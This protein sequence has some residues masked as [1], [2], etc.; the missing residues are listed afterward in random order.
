MKNYNFV[1]TEKN[2]KISNTYGG[3]TYTLVVYEVVKNELI[4]LGEAT[5]CTR[6]HKGEES[7]AWTVVMTN[8]PKIQKILMSR[9]KKAEGENDYYFQ[10]AKRG[11]YY[12]WNF[13]KFGVSLKGA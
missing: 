2:R 3:S 1:Y 7:E 11:Q 4:Y 10:E 6:G 8:R 9:I 12:T 13:K 5:A